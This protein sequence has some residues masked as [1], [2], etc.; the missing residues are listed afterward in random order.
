MKRCYSCFREFQDEYDVCP[1]C[2]WVYTLDAQQPIYLAPGTLLADGRYLIG[3]KIG[4]GGFGIVYKAWDNKLKTI[5]AIKEFFISRIM[6]RAKGEREV[7]V[8]PKRQEEFTYRKQRFLAEARTMA[9]FGNHKNIT[10]VFEYFEENG[11]AY[12]VMELL[13]GM[14][15]SD[16]LKQ[17]GGQLESG[18]AVEIALEIADALKSLHEHKIIHRDVAPD[19]IF[20]CSG[21]ELRIKL[22]DFGAAK[23][24]NNTDN[25]IDLILK[26]GYSPPEQYDKTGVIGSWT[27]IYAL[28]ATLYMILTGEKPDESTNRKTQDTM[29][30]PSELNPE[31]S[32]NLNNTIL[33]AMAL[34]RHMRFHNMEELIAAIKGERKVIT[35]A[36]EKKRLNTR[37]IVGITAALVVVAAGIFAA[38]QLFSVKKKENTLDPASIE[39][40]FSVKED[41]KETAAM[42][43]IKSDFEAAFAGVTLNLRAIPEADYAKTLL[44][45]AENDTLPQLF[46]STGASEEVLS[47]ARDLENVKDSDQFQDAMFLDQY[48]IYYSENK[49]MPL[50]IIA[51]LAVVVTSG[52]SELP[53]FTADYFTSLEDFS[54]AENSNGNI[55]RD[56]TCRELILQN[57]P[58]ASACPEAEFLNREKNAVPVL[59]TSTMQIDEVHEIMSRFEYR[60]VYYGAD[61]VNCQFTYE[62][63]IGS[64]TAAQTAA[65]E[66]LLSWMLGNVYQDYLMISVCQEGQIPVNKI[67]F[68][69]WASIG[70][71][72][73]SL[74]K[75]VYQKFVFEALTVDDAQDTSE[76]KTQPSGSDKDSEEQSA[77]SE[78]NTE[79]ESDAEPESSIDS[80][81]S[82]GKELSAGTELTSDAE[83][84]V[85]D[86]VHFGSYEQ[87]GNPSNGTESIEWLVLEADDQEL[88]LMSR[89]VLDGQKYDD[90]AAV[91]WEQ[92]SLRNWLNSDFYQIAFTEAEQQIIMQSSLSNENNPDYETAGGKETKDRIYLLSIE[93]AE[94]YQK[95]ETLQPFLACEATVYAQQQGIWTDTASD[96]CWYWL[97]SPGRFDSYAAGVGYTGMI[98]SYG[99][100]VDQEAY[101]VRPV[102]RVRLQEGE[103]TKAQQENEQIEAQQVQQLTEARQ[104]EGDINRLDAEDN[105]NG[106][107]SSADVPADDLIFDLPETLPLSEGAEGVEVQQLQEWLAQLGYLEGT[108]DGS[109]GPMTRTAV[110]SFQQ[111]NGLE[112]TGIVDAEVWTLLQEKRQ[113]SF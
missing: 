6:T 52:P 80:E 96:Y 25:V 95:E 30:A 31:I 76:I 91:N 47:A 97:R 36:A 113:E 56:S 60:Y 17:S 45:A 10:H 4:S 34:E 89:Y 14:S 57:F 19:N 109:F 66:R 11:T 99:T 51:P 92:C 101:G 64:G 70:G 18:F 24:E 12:I 65:A 79:L 9:Q 39:V 2:G 5:V 74:I 100:S 35:L 63:S 98:E 3:E 110:E 87:D 8:S 59:L 21:H 42:E 23:L 93:E 26:P 49:Q 37:R 38:F 7:I 13:E 40:W 105:A 72:K 71:E 58:E 33:K 16:Y 108:V 84:A 53:D 22:M 111:E 15:L 46:E 67:S 55:A 50:A 68:N 75:D 27:D 85:G 1:H 83:P 44:E 94:Q 20:I 102:L 82:E 77:A 73:H 106:Q 107:E 29:K 41:S 88:L 103:Q 90:Q 28:G 32:E 78:Q 43:E 62:W 54:A 61:E 104:N 112:I 69:N 86:M 81:Q 48:D